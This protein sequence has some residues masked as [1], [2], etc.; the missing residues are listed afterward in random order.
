M[1][2]HD[3]T[4]FLDT[5]ERVTGASKVYVVAHSQGSTQMFARLATDAAF[6]AR[7]R[8]LFALAP[9]ATVKNISFQLRFALRYAVDRPTRL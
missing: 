5:I 4:A 8:R 9:V 6:N 2:R 7:I 3:L 1:A